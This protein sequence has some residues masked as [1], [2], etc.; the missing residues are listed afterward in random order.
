ALSRTGRQARASQCGDPDPERG[1]RA[2]RA[3]L[4]R[5]G[6]DRDDLRAAR[7]RAIARQRDRVARL[8][9]DPGLHPGVRDDR[10]PGEPAHRHLLPLRRPA[11]ALI[12][13]LSKMR[14]VLRHPSGMV[15]FALVGSI[16]LAILLGP[17]F[18]AYDEVVS[19][20]L[21]KTMLPPSVEHPL[22]TDSL[23]RDLLGRVLWGGQLSLLLSVASVG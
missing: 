20:N 1:G 21:G 12:P 14:D 22:G 18:Y 10:D 9:P 4:R 17:V 11:A 7:A 23:G 15:G 13:M 8:P 5:S 16:V 3:S 19:I 6:A 2:V